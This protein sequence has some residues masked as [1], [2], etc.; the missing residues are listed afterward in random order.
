MARLEIYQRI[1]FFDWVRPQAEKVRSIL[2]GAGLLEDYEIIT[3]AD[4]V[5]NGFFEFN[6]VSGEYI[7]YLAENWMSIRSAEYNSET[8][9]L[10]FDEA[11][12]LVIMFTP[13]T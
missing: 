2:E 1:D 5:T 12:D 11:E 9:Q 4:G 13:E 8:Y 7:T 6:G 10:I 3:E